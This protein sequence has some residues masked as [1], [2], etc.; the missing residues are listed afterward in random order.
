MRVVIRLMQAAPVYVVMFF[1]LKMLPDD[2]DAFGRTIVI[3]RVT[4]MILVQ[5]A[6]MIPY[7]AEA[8][9]DML[10]HLRDGD[11]GKALLFLLNLLRGFNVVIIRFRRRDRR[12][13]GGW[14]HRT[15]GR[16]A[17]SHGRKSG[18]FPD[19]DR[20]VCYLFLRRK[21]PGTTACSAV[22]L[23]LVDDGA[24]GCQIAKYAHASLR[25]RVASQ[26]GPTAQF[27]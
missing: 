7:V 16:D 24:A 23:S 15:G 26:G 5:Y 27:G 4:V 19:R 22:P 11:V 13:R 9:F 21:P 14:R 2:I 17:G 20:S 25:A 6:Y 10:C 8:G 3:G 18:A 1:L 12:G